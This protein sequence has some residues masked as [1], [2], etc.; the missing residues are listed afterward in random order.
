[1]E[2]A[3][4]FNLIVIWYRINALAVGSEH[5]VIPAS[6]GKGRYTPRS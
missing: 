4:G 3:P 6:T 5:F 1:M 2:G